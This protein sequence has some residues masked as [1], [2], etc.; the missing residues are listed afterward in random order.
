MDERQMIKEIQ[1]G[2]KEYLNDIA[3][4]YYDDI[5][6]FCCFRTGDPSESYDL[7]Q[8]TFL[9]FIRYVE[10]YRYRNLKGYLLTIAMNVCRDYFSRRKHAADGLGETPAAE[11]AVDES[12]LAQCPAPG[13]YG[14]EERAVQSEI[15]SRL[16]DAL[17]QLPDMQRE[18]II[19]HYYY[20]MKFREIAKMTGVGA[21]TAKSRVRQGM[22]K[23]KGM[24]RREDFYGE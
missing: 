9:R 3:Q 19:L 13:E 4:R 5:Y 7:A 15:S 18:C 2:R 11:A 23:L 21:A 12:L 6:R 1:N 17:G 22:E 20:N 24:L 10:S 16:L 14:P 8:D